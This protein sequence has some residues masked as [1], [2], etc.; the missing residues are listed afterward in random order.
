MHP[1]SRE[2][3]LWFDPFGRTPRAGQA[4]VFLLVEAGNLRPAGAEWQSPE[5]EPAL[6]CTNGRGS[7]TN[8]VRKAD[9]SVAAGSGHREVDLL[10]EPRLQPAEPAAADRNCGAVGQLDRAAVA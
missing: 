5:H 7:C 9:R 3:S 10:I 1:G 6:P 2:S 8:C 4:T